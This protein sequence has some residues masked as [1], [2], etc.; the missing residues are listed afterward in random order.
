MAGRIVILG[1]GFGGLELATAL[2]S[3]LGSDADVILIDKAESFM[4]GY[5]KLELLFG[6][7]SREELSLPYSA[8]TKPGVRFV[9]ET[10]TAIDPESR[11]VTTDRD[12][13]QADHL[14]VALGADMAY[15]A[16]PGLTEAEAFYSVAGAAQLAGA[17]GSFASGHAVIGVCGIPYKCTPAPSECALLLHDEL[18]SRGVRDD[19]TISYIA[20]Q[21]NPV[22]PSPDAAS[23]VLEAFAEHDIQFVPGRRIASLDRDRSVARL[24]DGTEVAYDL[25]LGVPKHRAPDVVLASGM[26]VDD[27][28]PVDPATLTTRYPEVYAVGDCA[29]AGVPKAGAFAESAAAAVAA[30][31]IAKLRGEEPPQPYRGIGACYVEFGRGCVGRVNIDASSGLPPKGTFDGPSEEL[32]AE[33]REFG[34]S[35]RASWFGLEVAP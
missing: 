30:Q 10:I 23:A 4:F 14:V 1:A 6:R 5:S 22:P 33:K 8:I 21:P 32:A 3:A 12:Q 25:F 28:V 35:R 11:R 18:V 16:T 7:A 2:S 27:Y 19:C 20:P 13:Y 26:A 17:V 24:D 15:E 9:R 31:L 29:T 34:S